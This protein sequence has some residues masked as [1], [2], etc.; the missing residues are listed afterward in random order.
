MTGYPAISIHIFSHNVAQAEE[1]WNV[2]EKH[3]YRP[4]NL[5]HFHLQG[6]SCVLKRSLTLPMSKDT[7]CNDKRVGN[8]PPS[9]RS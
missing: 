8:L 2:K 3:K 7:H 5:I 9:V 6:C 4:K 1:C